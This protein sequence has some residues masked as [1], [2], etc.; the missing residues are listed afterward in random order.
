MASVVV[1]GADLI[2]FS[3]IEA[4]LVARGHDV[5]RARAVDASASAGAD[6][7]ICD[8][9]NVDPADAVARLRPAQLLAFGS[10]EQPDALRRARQAGF[11]RVVARSAVAERLPELVADLLGAS[12]TT[13]RVPENDRSMR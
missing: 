8:A 3:R 10:H 2:L 13:A 5:R 1:V 7:A 6:L 12:S 4:Q 9:E 11:D